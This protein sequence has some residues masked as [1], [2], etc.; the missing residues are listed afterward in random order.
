[1][2][3]PTQAKTRSATATPIPALAPV[4]RP[5]AGAS[6]SS[7]VICTAENRTAESIIAASAAHG[8]GAGELVSG[9]SGWNYGDES[10]G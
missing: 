6:G 8:T 3:A 1:M 5:G 10:G 2:Q 4:E 7:A 9:A